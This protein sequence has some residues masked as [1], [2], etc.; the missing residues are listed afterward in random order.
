MYVCIII[1]IKCNYCYFTVSAPIFPPMDDNNMFDGDDPYGVMCDMLEKKIEE[2][3]KLYINTS[4]YS[5]INQL[6]P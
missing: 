5:H 1:R 3:S 4:I 6:K 2:G